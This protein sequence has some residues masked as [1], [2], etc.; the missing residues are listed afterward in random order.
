ML[1]VSI[2]LFCILFKGCQVGTDI[3]YVQFIRGLCP[4]IDVEADMWDLLPEISDARVGSVACFFF[5]FFFLFCFFFVFF[6]LNKIMIQCI[7]F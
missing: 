5:F 6:F 7:S 2:C 3:P 1:T 4:S